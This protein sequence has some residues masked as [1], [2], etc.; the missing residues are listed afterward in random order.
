M[1]QFYDVDNSELG[2]ILPKVEYSN[3]DCER[4]AKSINGECS[5]YV[6]CHCMEYVEFYRLGLDGGVRYSCNC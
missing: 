2:E 3:I 4:V 5:G 6:C 1:V